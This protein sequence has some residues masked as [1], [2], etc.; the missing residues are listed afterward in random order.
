VKTPGGSGWLIGALIAVQAVVGTA[1]GEERLRAG[2]KDLTLAGG[3]SVSHDRS[4]V[5]GV[6]GFHLLPHFGYVLTDEHGPSWVR[7]NFELLGGPTLVHLSSH[8]AS[9]TAGGVSLLARWI[10]APSPTVRPYLEF[11]GGVLAGQLDFR[12]TNC[13]VNYN[14]QGGPG[15]LIFVSERT[16]ITVGYRFH[17]LSNGG[18]CDKNLGLNSS[19]FTVGISHFLP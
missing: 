9:S 4:G 17:H 6:D 16:A 15:V 10:F 8:S 12:Q 18:R 7:G 2:M 11:G 14:F 19:L 1:A 3:Y 5:E 13:D